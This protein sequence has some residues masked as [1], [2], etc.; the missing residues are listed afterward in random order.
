MKT[1]LLYKALV[2]VAMVAGT[3]SCVNEWLDQEPSTGVDAGSAVTTTSDLTSVRAG[4]YAALK[5]NSSLTDYYGR[6]MFIYGDVRGEDVQYNWIDGSGRGDF[7]YYMTYSTAS[8]FNG[9]AIWQTPFVVISR[10]NYVIDYAEGGTITDAED[11]QATISQYAAEARVLRAMALFDLTRIYGTPY[12]EDQGES[13]GAPIITEPV[14]DAGANKPERSTVAECYTQIEQDLTDAINS[15]ALPE[16][17]TQGYVNVWTAK[18][19]QVRVYITKGE[20]ANALSVAED[21]IAN[22]PYTLWTT[23]EYADAWNKNNSAH[24][25]ELILE[26]KITDSIDWTDREGI[27]Y[28]YADLYGVDAAGGYGDTIVTKDFSEMLASDPEDVRNDILLKPVGDP[29]VYTSYGDDFVEHGVFINKLPQPD[30]NT[31]AA[32]QNVPLLRLSEVYL[33]AAEAAYQEGDLSRAAE[34]FNDIITNR[35]TDATKTVTAGDITLDRIYVERRK[36][37]VD[38]GQRYFDVLRRGETVTRYTDVNNRGWHD[39]LS[40]EART[41]SRDSEKALPLIPQ[42]ELDV[43]PNM[44]QNPEY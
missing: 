11:N 40:E 9:N 21:I 5:G 32:Y 6:Q 29:S 18:A 10:A 2:C 14:D 31:S 37:L 42:S 23:A 28:C 25:N 8:D 20:W 35:T 38:E 16:D 24:E 4:L 30:E 41:F 33:S 36:E 34:L 44:Q 15:G 26:M 3:S 19:L 12:T 22:S 13:L 39:A 7:Y 17:K 1:T 43:N 27:A